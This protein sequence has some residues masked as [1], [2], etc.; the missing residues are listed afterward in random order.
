MSAPRGRECAISPLW[1]A[2]WRSQAPSC[3][4]VSAASS[5]RVGGA[6]VASMKPMGVCTSGERSGSASSP[7]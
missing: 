6:A 7:P 2:A 5:A 4:R 1:A 3:A